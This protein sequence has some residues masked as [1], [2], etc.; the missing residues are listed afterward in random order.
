MIMSR[1]FGTDGVRGVANSELSADLAFKLGKAGAMVLSKNCSGTPKIIVG[2][3]TRISGTM[4]ENALCAGLCSVGATV[5]TLGVIPTPAVAY[6]VRA[7]KA[8]AGVVISASHNPFEYNGIKFFNSEGYKLGDDIEDEIEAMIKSDSYGVCPTGE[9]V[10]IC[11]SDTDAAR[12]YIDFEKSNISCK[13]DGLNITVDCSNGANSAIA[14]DC[15]RE[16]GANVKTCFC[17]P[18]GVNINDGCGSTHI[19]KLCE[20]VGSD[21]D[22]DIGIAFD[23]DADRMLCCDENG[24]KL[25]GDEIMLIVGKYL[26]EKGELKKDS[27]VVTVMSNLGFFNDSKKLDISAV[28]TK[29][30]D[31]Y[32][33]EE[34]MK[35]GYC[36]GGEESGHIIYL[37]KNTTGDGLMSALLLLEVMQKTGK[38]L[39]ELRKIIKI[40]PQ[41]LSNAKVKNEFK[42]EYKNNERITKAIEELE[43]EFKDSGRVL[44]RPSG[45]EPLIRV[46]LEG[47]DKDYLKTRAEELKC[48]IEEELG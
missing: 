41:V 46:M 23:G 27:I 36:L 22:C 39:S 25:T 32:V 35:S 47:S 1:M 42:N 2:R 20:M 34:M 28:A 13:L 10:G 14:P 44:I 43:S 24:D 40:L 9:K 15:F 7:Y 26:K 38:K 11:V 3:D 19:E 18:D 48:I 5:I 30:G 17:E 4:L 12:T 21:K 45:T 6:L 16:L 33:L 29:V 8:D 31:R 37:T